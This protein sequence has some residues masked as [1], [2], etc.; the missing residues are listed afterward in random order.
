ML[1]FKRHLVEL[2]R[3]GRK[4]QTVR[5]WSRPLLRKG[6]ISYT[7]GLGKMKITAVDLLPSLAALTEADAVADG[8]P[9]LAALLAEIHKIYGKPLPPNRQLYRVRFSWPIDAAGKTLVL[10]HAP[11]PPSKIE[12]RKSKIE[13]QKSPSQSLS[14]K[15]QALRSYVLAFFAKK[16][17]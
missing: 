16:T 1:L 14:Q 10:E 13:N 15:R 9:T 5:F 7:P 8:F 2:I 4:R 6:Q 11:S 12:N 3:C 17:P